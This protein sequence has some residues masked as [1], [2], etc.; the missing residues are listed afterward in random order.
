MASWRLTEVDY[1]LN[2]LGG[3]ERSFL[4]A[5]HADQPG[6]VATVR[7]DWQGSVP[8]KNDQLRC[9]QTSQARPG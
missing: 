2:T 7:Y 3:R 1:L 4:R 9:Q 5:M 8:R 6:V